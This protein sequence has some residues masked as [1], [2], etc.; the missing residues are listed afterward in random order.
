M[1]NIKNDNIL[2]IKKN[3]IFT[4]ELKKIVNDGSSKASTIR[5]GRF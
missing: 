3:C 2:L 1:F 5:S 4:R